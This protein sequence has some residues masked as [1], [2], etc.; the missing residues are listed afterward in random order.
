[1]TSRDVVAD[2]S[3]TSSWRNSAAAAAAAGDDD[4]DVDK[5]HQRMTA[6]DHT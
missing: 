3:L 2:E 1:M 5:S 6:L 4:D